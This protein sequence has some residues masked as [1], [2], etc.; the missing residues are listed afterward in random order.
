MSDFKKIQI[1]LNRGTK[2]LQNILNFYNS[3]TKLMQTL[4]SNNLH[5][6]S[7]NFTLKDL[8]AYF[9]DNDPTAIEYFL[10]KHGIKKYRE[11]S[12]EYYALCDILSCFDLTF[13]L[14]GA[15]K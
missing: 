12:K 9:P 13:Q 8:M 2:S 5:N 6:V 14:L 7:I 15:P 4:E 1:I 11:E 3:V 10:K